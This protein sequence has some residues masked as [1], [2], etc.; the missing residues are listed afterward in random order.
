MKEPPITEEPHIFEDLKRI[1][2]EKNNW[3]VFAWTL[4]TAMTYPLIMGAF[5]YFMLITMGVIDVEQATLSLE[6]GQTTDAYIV[7][8]III[9]GVNGIGIALGSLVV[10]RMADK[11]RRGAMK[12]IYCLYLPVCIISNL[13]IGI[14]LGLGV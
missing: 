14:L 5:F 3:K 7:L 4:I 13:F 11:S 10:G 8:N 9:A 2:T 12:F 6:A 1:V